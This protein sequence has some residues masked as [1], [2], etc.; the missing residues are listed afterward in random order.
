MTGDLRNLDEE[1]I[2]L[3]YT[4]CDVRGWVTPWDIYAELTGRCRRNSKR[5]DPIPD[6]LNVQR[7]RKVILSAGFLD[8]PPEKEGARKHY[9]PPE[10]DTRWTAQV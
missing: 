8:L 7:I 6:G 3:A 10:V 5:T 9:I 1:I 2:N 4:F